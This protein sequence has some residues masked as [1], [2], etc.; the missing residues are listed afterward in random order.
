[1]ADQP[2]FFLL[3]HIS[4]INHPTALVVAHLLFL[5]VD[6][7]LL[8]FHQSCRRGRRCL[9]FRNGLIGP[10]APPHLKRKITYKW[11]LFPQLCNKLDN[12]RSY[13]LPKGNRA[14]SSRVGGQVLKPATDSDVQS[15]KSSIDRGFPVTGVMTQGYIHIHEDQYRESIHENPL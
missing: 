13:T 3:Q 2:P 9:R 6:D 11:T 1:M 4:N 10:R 14:P 5:L 7:S 15:R 8:N 12:I